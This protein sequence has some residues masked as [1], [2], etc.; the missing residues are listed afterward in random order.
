MK[1]FIMIFIQIVLLIATLILGL[2]YNNIIL[3]VSFSQLCS[4]AYTIYRRYNRK[5]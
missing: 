1:T 4:I 2:K 3:I 5:N